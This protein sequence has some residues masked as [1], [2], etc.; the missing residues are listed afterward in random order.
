[1]SSKCGLSSALEIVLRHA[2]ACYIVLRYIQTPVFF[3]QF[4][5]TFRL[6]L[7]WMLYVPFTLFP[8]HTALTLCYYN[9]MTCKILLASFAGNPW[10]AGGFGIPSVL[11]LTVVYQKRLLIKSRITGNAGWLISSPKTMGVILIIM[12]IASL[13]NVS[14]K[15]V[16]I[17]I[18]R[19]IQHL[20]WR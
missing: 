8:I 7:S 17:N 4:G 1:M 3:L 2:I 10:V 6:A 20:T 19:Y 11:T 13:L 16:S 18:N 12:L 5:F 15:S 9:G 14:N